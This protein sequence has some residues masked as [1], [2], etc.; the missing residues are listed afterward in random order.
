M[1]PRRKRSSRNSGNNFKPINKNPDFRSDMSSTQVDYPKV[2][3][4]GLKG[5]PIV[6]LGDDLARM[7]VEAAERQ[8]TP[9][10]NDDIIIVSHTIV[11]RAEGCIVDLKTVKPSEFALRIARETDKDPRQV[12]VILRSSKRI[13]RMSQGVIICE[14]EH[15]FICANAGVDIS[16]VSGG[17]M[18]VT[19]PADP[20]Q[21]ARKI[22]EGLRKEVEVAVLISDTHGRPLRNGTINVAIGASGLDPLWDR[23]GE[24]DL[25][26][27]VL[28]S[29]VTAVGDE[30][31]SAAE[32]VIGQASEAIPVSIV[33]G[34]RFKKGDLSAKCLIRDRSQDLFL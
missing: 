6:E 33:R 34:Y 11:A 30:L 9:L 5:L 26:G 2:E 18:V 1:L 23:R 14:T 16:N 4:I 7:I 8:G 12:E 20:D 29:K 28:R 21:S 31:C 13:V 22:R 25:H 15:G 10:R 19:L 24:T 27:R 3:I 17:D 32:L